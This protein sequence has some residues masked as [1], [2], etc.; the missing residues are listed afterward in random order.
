MTFEYILFKIFDKELGVK[1]GRAYYPQFTA[2]EL[3]LVYDHWIRNLVRNMDRFYDSST[4][5]HCELANAEFDRYCAENDI[6][7]CERDEYKDE[8]FQGYWDAC[9]YLDLHMKRIKDFT[10]VNARQRGFIIDGDDLHVVT[11]VCPINIYD[12]I[13][14]N[15]VINND[16]EEQRRLAALPYKDYLKTRHWRRVRYTLMI[17]RNRVCTHRDCAQLLETHHGSDMAD[18]HVHHLTYKNRG[19]ER[20]KDVLLL[21]NRHHK[22]VHNGNDIPIQQEISWTLEFRPSADHYVE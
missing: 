13:W 17:T 19:N 9:D 2:D 22:S 12:E 18:L 10:G 3:A 20:F 6:W 4:A 8:F 16:S 21:C 5:Y 7:E 11:L 15:W 1:M 14:F